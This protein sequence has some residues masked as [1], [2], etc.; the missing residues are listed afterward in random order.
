MAALANGTM[1]HALDFDDA[2]PNQIG[3][4]AHPSVP[5]IPCVFA[6]GEKY[7]LSGKELLASYIL[8]FEIETRVG[9]VFESRLVKSGWHTTPVIGVI[10]AAA[11]ASKVLRL[12]SEKTQNALGIAASFSSGLLHNFGTMTKP[13]HVGNA[14]QQGIMS[15]LLA[16]R[17]FTACKDIFDSPMIYFKAFTGESKNDISG[18]TKELGSSWLMAKGIGFKPYP[19]CRATHAGIDAALELKRRY[20]FDVNSISDIICRAS[21]MVYDILT[22]HHPKTATEAKFSLEYCLSCAL[23]DGRV[24]L[25]HFTAERLN[26]PRIKELMEK[27][28]LEPASSEVSYNDIGYQLTIRLNDGNEFSHRVIAPKGEPDNPMTDE[29]MALKFKDCAGYTLSSTNAERCLQLILN[30]DS[31]SVINELMEILRAGNNPK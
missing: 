17:G 10:G 23:L 5:V 2:Y 13:L 24:S 31:V 14:A 20:Q 16:R 11:A 9:S 3:I 6:L 18:L 22:Y 12:H 28:R 19:S 27:V 21:K 8:G 7:N 30:L 15:A 29:D 4:P 26:D 1:S 25:Q